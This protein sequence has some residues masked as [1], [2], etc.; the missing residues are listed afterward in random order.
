MTWPLALFIVLASFLVFPWEALHAHQ[1]AKNPRIGTAS[2]MGDESQGKTMANGNPFRK[3][4]LTC[5]SW[6]YPLGTRLRVTYRKKS[7][8]VVV[9]DRGP[10]KYLRREIDLSEAAFSLICDLKLGLCLVSV[11]K[12]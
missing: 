9:T 2:W 1:R 12:L 6:H 7:V 8:D 3:E 11:Q 5:A 4:K 10:A